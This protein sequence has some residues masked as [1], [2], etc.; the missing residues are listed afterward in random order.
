MS[1]Y[2]RTGPG[3][4]VL[5]FLF[6]GES[7]SVDL[8]STT[9]GNNSTRLWSIEGLGDDDHQF[10]GQTSATNGSAAANIWVDYFE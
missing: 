10:I 5:N 2:G 4:A 6:D 7:K 3:G 9:P 8:N 1:L